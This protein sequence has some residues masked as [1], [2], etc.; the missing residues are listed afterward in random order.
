MRREIEIEG[1]KGEMLENYTFQTRCG[2]LFVVLV[3]AAN[4]GE[5][6]EIRRVLKWN[7]FSL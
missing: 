6:V 5:C 3:V 7:T 4:D 2:S 1:R